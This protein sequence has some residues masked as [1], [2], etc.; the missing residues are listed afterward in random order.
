MMLV[1]T[2]TGAA[3]RL[4]AL[5]GRRRALAILALG[6]LASAAL[7]PL[8][9]VPLLAVSFTSLVWLLDGVPHDGMR[10]VRRAFMVGWWFALGHFVTGLYWI[11]HAL[12]VDAAQFA[13]MI[14]FA[15][16][17]LSAV[18]AVFAGLATA[19]VHASGLRGIAGIFALAVAWTAAEWL[20]GHLFTGFPWNLI[21][22]AWAGSDAMMQAAAVFGLY[23]L[24]MITVAMAALPA[25]AAYGSYESMRRW[26]GPLA[27]AGVLL[28]LWSGGAVRLAGAEAGYVPNV[29]LR[30]VQPDIPQSL[31]WN[32]ALRERHLMST[33]ALTREPGFER[34]T[35]V[36]WPEAASPFALSDSP[37]VRQALATVVPPGGLLLTGAPRVARDPTGFRV[38][39]SLYALDERGAIAAFYDKFHLV[40]FGEYVPF[41]SILPIEKI[42]PGI[43][44][45]SAGPGPRTLALPGLP[46]ASPLICY[47][48]I[49][50]AHVVDPA[51][52]PGWLLNVTNDAW[53]G[54]S[55]GPYQHFAASRFRAVEE[56]LPLVRA[57][58]NGISAV[59]DA[60]GRVTAR[61]GLGLRGVVDAE[62]PRAIEPTLYARVGDIAVA[63]LGLLLLAA[64]FGLRT[65]SDD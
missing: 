46:K 50:P 27:A 1:R 3:A 25:T 44:D 4:V 62:L 17:G 43:G 60:Y 53:F 30:L 22:T 41:R 63:G 37:E 36:I 5:S 57:A 47:E 28:V 7:P 64:A 34:V 10:G 65:L 8:H 23:G 2:L 55:S 20:R 45:F 16:V 19:A 26:F 38:W 39:N 29:R 51:E 24:G 59:A 11:A 35:H 58:N 12:L 54:I 61:L 33:M 18:L 6:A 31:K 52:R 13:W 42:T 15:V 56:G 32:P 40:P 9:L 21:G 48:V 49:F 14:P